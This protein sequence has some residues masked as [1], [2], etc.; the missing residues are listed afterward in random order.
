MP[1]GSSLDSLPQ[2]TTPILF[3]T[4]AHNLPGISSGHRIDYYRPEEH[5]RL[6]TDLASAA[7]HFFDLFAKSREFEEYFSNADYGID[8]ECFD[9]AELAAFRSAFQS[10]GRDCFTDLEGRDVFN[11]CRKVVALQL[12]D[13]DLSVTRQG[14]QLFNT[15]MEAA[16]PADDDR[17]PHCS[18]RLESVKEFGRPFVEHLAAVA[19]GS[20][21][22][23]K[24]APLPQVEPLSQAVKHPDWPRNDLELEKLLLLVDWHRQATAKGD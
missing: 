14:I 7:E 18:I 20:A 15:V 12:Q 10:S 1:S 11:G 2:M 23:Q 9:D 5:A 17:H 13:I 24:S 16:L 8:E 3:V 19:S 4:R 6:R 22:R 21:F